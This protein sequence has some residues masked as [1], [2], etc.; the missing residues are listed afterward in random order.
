MPNQYR[1]VESGSED[2]A[3]HTG[4]SEMTR[5]KA[6]NGNAKGDKPP[7]EEEGPA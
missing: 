3:A 6:N 4:R 2:E 7:V 5:T 1:D